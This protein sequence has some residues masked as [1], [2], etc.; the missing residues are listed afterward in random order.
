MRGWRAQLVQR[1]NVNMQFDPNARRDDQ[2]TAEPLPPN[3]RA[4]RMDE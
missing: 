3:Y 2:D 1:D 4:P